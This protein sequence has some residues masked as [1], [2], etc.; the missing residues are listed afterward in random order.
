MTIDSSTFRAT[1]GH[2]PTG[3]CVITSRTPRGAAVGMTVGTFTS[4]SLDP[5]LVGFFPDKK[6]TSWP[7]IAA[8]GRFCVNV[9]ADDQEWLGRRFASRGEDRFADVICAS[10]P[11]GLP[12]LDGSI[13]WIDC[14]IHSVSNAGD[15]FLVLGSVEAMSVER[16]AAPLVFHQGRFAHVATPV[17]V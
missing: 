16:A 3:V 11:T 17:A 15:H 14:T 10:S 4:V 13:A 7:E 6:S 12:I 2:Y 9:L 1:L 5:P 8:T